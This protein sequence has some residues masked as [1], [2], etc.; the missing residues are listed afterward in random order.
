[1]SATG[2]IP[3]PGARRP[4]RVSEYAALRSAII[5]TELN[6]IANTTLKDQLG[7]EADGDAVCGRLSV[8]SPGS[9]C[10]A[11]SWMNRQVITVFSF[12][13]LG[14]AAMPAQC[15]V[16]TYGTGL[17]SCEIYLAAKEQGSR[18]GLAFIDWVSGY[19]SGVNALSNRVNNVL[20]DT[21]LQGTIYWLDGFCRK[22]SQTAVAVAMDILVAGARSTVARPTVEVIIYGAGF[23]SCSTYLGARQARGADEAAFVDWLGGYFSAV[24]AFSLSTDNVL[25]SSDLTASIVWLDGYC[26][27]HPGVRFAAAAEARLTPA[28]HDR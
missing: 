22:H 6:M 19:V 18:E 26:Q 9:G 12:V 10:R 23:K 14:C 3:R 8:V 7:I 24:N 4:G 2:R 27:A 25:N 16:V 5:L 28:G 1:L 21:N 11:A 15:K 20:G 17:K 13:M